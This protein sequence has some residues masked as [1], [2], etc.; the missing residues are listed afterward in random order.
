MPV[1]MEIDI[2]KTAVTNGGMNAVTSGVI[3]VVMSV[4]I[5]V[6]TAGNPSLQVDI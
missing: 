4:G 1:G 6:I 3:N 5:I 2:V